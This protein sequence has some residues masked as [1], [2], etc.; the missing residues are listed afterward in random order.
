MVS[1]RCAPVSLLFFLIAV[2]M[3]NGFFIAK[4]EA[5]P[6]PVGDW[7]PQPVF[8]NVDDSPPFN[9]SINDDI[10][11][12]DPDSPSYFVYHVGPPNAADGRDYGL[13][14]TSMLAHLALNYMDGVAV[15]FE[16]GVYEMR[17]PIIVPSR[18]C[19]M[20]RG[21]G[22]NGTRLLA[23]KKIEGALIRSEASTHINVARLSI[24]T[25]VSYDLDYG[26]WFKLCNYLKIDDVKI[27]R[28]K[29]DG[30]R[31]D[32]T[33]KRWS[34]HSVLAGLKIFDVRRYGIAVSQAHNT[35]ITDF[36]VN[37][38]RKYG[39]LLSAGDNNTYVS[40]GEIMG[41]E[42]G[43]AMKQGRSSEGPN[44][45]RVNTLKISGAR[46]SGIWIKRSTDVKL[47]NVN[48]VGGAICYRINQSSIEKTGGNCTAKRQLVGSSDALPIPAA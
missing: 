29:F 17:S 32:G 7:S 36:S 42:I 10:C 27:T 20:G 15:R 47:T 41:A 16:T 23:T 38:V 4:A 34:Y 6:T 22:M 5:Q 21:S 1:L 46:R 12:P 2:L 11:N 45:V 25:Y 33:G 35:H 13:T 19:I 37:N 18:T 48:I 44:G 24:D 8:T 14:V 43:L 28:V 9:N 30:V 3:M 31:V 40:R 26:L 39:V